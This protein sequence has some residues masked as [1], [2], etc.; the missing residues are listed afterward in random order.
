MAD[1][2]KSR[3]ADATPVT[4]APHDPQWAE[5]AAMECDRIRTAAGDT[6]VAV[7]HIGSTSIAGIVAKPTIDLLPVVDSLDALEARRG[8]IE[9]LGYFWRGEFGIPGRRYC[10]LERDGR[11]IFHVHFFAGGSENIAR[12]LAFRDYLRAHRDEAL[13]Y[14]AIKRAAAEAHPHN[15]LAYNEHKSAWIRACLERALAWAQS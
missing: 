14:E 5:Q 10:V 9:Q 6:L 11:R 7:H 2:T 1:E 15:S 12:H 8:Q 4:L 13:A 3:R